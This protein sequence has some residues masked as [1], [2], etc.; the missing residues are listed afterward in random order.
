M[1]ALRSRL[2][3]LSEEGHQL[4]IHLAPPCATF[5]LARNRSKR[6]QLRSSAHPGGLPHLT[7]RIALA[8]LTEANTIALASFSLATWA[9]GELKAVEALENPSSS[10]MWQFAEQS[11]IDLGTFN[12]RTFSQCMY[13]TPYRK[14]TRLR[15]WGAG[16]RGMDRRCASNGQHFACG[17]SI[18]AGHTRLG[19]GGASTA[20]AA[21]YP[22]GVCKA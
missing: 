10:Y 11:S 14:D 22:P 13:G 1:S 12:D 7:D 15:V 9:H 6:T 8:R 5:S 2:K 17:I 21:T 4:L 3:E 20:A 16:F 19:F 18:A